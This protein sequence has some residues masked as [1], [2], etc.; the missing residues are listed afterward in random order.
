[1][2]LFILLSSF[3]SKLL[4]I[5]SVFLVAFPAFVD[6][7]PL[8]YHSSL[9][10][11]SVLCGTQGIL[12]WSLVCRKRPLLLAFGTVGLNKLLST[13]YKFTERIFKID[14]KAQDFPCISSILA[15]SIV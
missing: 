10:P 6:K 13:R 15:H 1:M 3:H 11:F 5:P 12:P 9:A 7:T 4:C 14:I 8:V 2:T